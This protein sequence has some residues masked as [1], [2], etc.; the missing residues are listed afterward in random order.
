VNSKLSKVA[1]PQLYQPNITFYRNILFRSRL[2][3]RWAAFFDTL[4]INWE[5][6][7]KTFILPNHYQ[8][9]PDFWVEN[10]GWIEIKPDEKA[11][12]L[13]PKYILFSKQLIEDFGVG[14]MPESKYFSF[15]GAKPF[16]RQS[17]QCIEPSIPK[18]QFLECPICKYKGLGIERYHDLRYRSI[19]EMVSLC[20][21]VFPYDAKAR[22]KIDTR[23][24][25][26]QT[27]KFEEPKHIATAVLQAL[28]EI[29]PKLS[30]DKPVR[31]AFE[32][33]ARN[34]VTDYNYSHERSSIP[35][36]LETSLEKMLKHE[37]D[38][39][40]LLYTN[41]RVFHPQYGEGIITKT[42][43]ENSRLWIEFLEGIYEFGEEEAREELINYSY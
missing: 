17:I 34:G 6:E 15:C 30:D 38:R 11:F 12:S 27:Y 7:P 26:V 18:L 24:D 14:D 31:L 43:R 28:Q 5:Y 29:I 16:D 39:T 9:T 19:L 10:L 33:L 42:D 37:G 41:S 35:F 21:D 20:G 36:K 32:E 1:M 40:V 2:E 4:D 23:F 8:Y 22:H 3:A 13:N 25:C